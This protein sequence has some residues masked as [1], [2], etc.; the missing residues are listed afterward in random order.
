[1]YKGYKITVTEDGWFVEKDNFFLCDTRAM[2]GSKFQS[3]SHKLNDAK[4]NIDRWE[5]KNTKE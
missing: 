5:E 4:K 3:L 2:D 1:M